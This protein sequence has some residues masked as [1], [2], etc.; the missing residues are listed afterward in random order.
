M[1]PAA[2]PH[3]TGLPDGRLGITR[4]SCHTR[5]AI[6][7]KWGETSA[8]SNDGI[9]QEVNKIWTLNLFFISSHL[10]CVRLNRHKSKY[11]IK[12]IIQSR[13]HFFNKKNTHDLIALS[14]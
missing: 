7:S 9:S 14:K 1:Q 11:K 2:A 13:M 4:L 6:G 12:V 10:S 5:W 3:F 8:H